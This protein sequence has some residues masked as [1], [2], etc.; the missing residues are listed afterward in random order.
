MATLKHGL[1]IQK[2]G[3]NGLSKPLPPKRKTIFDDDDNSE[4]EQASDQKDANTEEISTFD[5]AAPATT[6]KSNPPSKLL[7]SRPSKAN[8][9]APALD[10]DLSTLRVHQQRIE[11]AETLDPSIYDYDAAYDALHAKQTAKKTAEREEAVQRK[12]KYMENLLAAAEVRKR[13]QLRAKDRLL[14]KEREEEGEEFK[15]KDKF[16]TEA[17][18]KQQEEVRKMEE[19]EAKREEEETKKRRGKG[20]SGFYRSVMDDEEKKHQDAVKAAAELKTTEVVDPPEE[21]TNENSA[22]E[23]ARELN[24]KGA[25]VIINDE[26]QVSDKRQLLTAGLNVAPKRK[27]DSLYSSADIRSS[28]T[29]RPAQSQDSRGGRDAQRAMRERQSRM[30]EAQLEAAAKK[31]AEEEAEEREKVER[32]AKSRKTEGD[33]SSARERYLQRKREAAA[34]AAAEGKE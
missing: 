12:P 24:A 17:Y 23:M 25:N 19:E 27:A 14:Q 11:E 22:A 4:D 33:I 1:N 29:Q 30:M 8:G 21:Q 9:T 15:D 28:T 20:M 5:V 7:P 2:K 3:P 26:G 18:K 13:D 10:A 31:A 34:A 6:S 32:A 16:V